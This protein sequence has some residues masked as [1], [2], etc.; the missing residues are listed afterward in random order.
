MAAP[1]DL[2]GTCWRDDLYL[3]HRGLD[4]GNV[5]EYFAL[6]PFCVRD[7]DGAGSTVAGPGLQ[8]LL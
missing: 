3:Q 2:T 7:P 5:L 4:L 1:E 8:Q 6:S